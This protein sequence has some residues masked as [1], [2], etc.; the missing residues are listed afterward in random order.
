MCV[1][2]FGA[3]WGLLK[4]LVRELMSIAA[5]VVAFFAAPIFGKTVGSLIPVLDLSQWL[6]D[7]AGYAIV[8]IAV[9]ILSTILAQRM[10]QLVSFIGLGVLDRLLG[11]AFATVAAVVV[12]LISTACINMSSFKNNPEWTRANVAPVLEQL[13]AQVAPFFFSELRKVY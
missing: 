13:L 1:L 7:A 6:Q 4:G 12:L 2:A 10:R 3:V 5:W 9:L 8:V 11:A